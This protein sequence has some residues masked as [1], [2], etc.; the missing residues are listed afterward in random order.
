M[1]RRII[2]FFIFLATCNMLQAQFSQHARDSI[3]RLSY[4]DHQQMMGLL[5]ITSIRPGPS[6]NPEAADAANT[7]ESKVQP[8]FLPD[9]LE[10]NNGTRVKTANSTFFITLAAFQR[11]Q[12]KCK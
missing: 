7:D 12:F 1:L 8:Y 5:G 9:P 11:F 4:T 10:F 2:F 3:N 6:G